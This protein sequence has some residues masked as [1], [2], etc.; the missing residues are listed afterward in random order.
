MGKNQIL[1]FLDSLLGH[2]SW[3]ISK[4]QDHQNYLEEV[5]VGQISPT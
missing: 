1:G 5:K 3:K 2:T 4:E